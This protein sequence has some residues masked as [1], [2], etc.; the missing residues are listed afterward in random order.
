MVLRTL[1]ACSPVVLAGLD[2]FSFS[3]ELYWGF[4]LVLVCLEFQ[5]GLST[6]WFLSSGLQALFL[7]SIL[8]IRHGSWWFILSIFI[9]VTAAGSSSEYSFWVACF[10]LRSTR[11]LSQHRSGAIDRRTDFETGPQFNPF[12]PG[13]NGQYGRVSS[14]LSI[15]RSQAQTRRQVSQP[16]KWGFRSFS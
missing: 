16:A 5:S 2:L 9:F 6:S 7:D 10:E 8:Y 11:R 15:C 1:F 12:D 14:R 13:G 4:Y 3:L